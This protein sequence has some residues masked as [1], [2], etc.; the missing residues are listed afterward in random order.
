M[1]TFAIAGACGHGTTTTT[2]A[3][4]PAPA[5]A[6][7]AG[8][9]STGAGTERDAVTLFFAA[10]N[11]GDLQAMGAIWGDESGPARDRWPRDELEQRELIM[12]RCLRHDTFK[13][14]S[15]TPGTSGQRVFSV[16]LT[17]R[18]LTTSTT[19][20]AARGPGGRWYV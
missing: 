16:E 17:R 11:N 5:P 12:Q 6:A 3:P 8:G 15:T 10:V 13:V 7:A 4:T 1:I 2:T 14:L 19:L 18:G 9:S 20:T